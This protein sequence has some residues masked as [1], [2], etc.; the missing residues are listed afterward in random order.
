MNDKG[1]VLLRDVCTGGEH[2]VYRWL[3]ETLEDSEDV[4]K[5]IEKVSIWE[6]LTQFEESAGDGAVWTYY[7]SKDEALA[8]EKIVLAA[9]GEM[10]GFK[11]EVEH[12]SEIEDMK[13]KLFVE[14]PVT[15]IE[16][17]GAEVIDESDSIEE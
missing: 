7:L 4:V 5:I 17:E 3:L 14:E 12:A 2:K 8:H 10:F 6:I 16:I 11:F 9:L 15:T 1:Q 13:E